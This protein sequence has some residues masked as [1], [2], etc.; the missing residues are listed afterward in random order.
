MSRI[1]TNVNSLIAQR[2]LGQQNKGL[3]QSLERLSTG[4]AINRGADNPAGLIASEKLR[5]DQAGL[6]AAIGNAQ[7]ADQIVNI[8][9]GGLQKVQDLLTQVN[10]LVGQTAS[11]AGLSDDEKAAN[12]LQ[13]DSILQTIDRIAAT[14]SF[15]GTKLLNG[16]YDFRVTGQSSAVADFKVNGAKITDGGTVAVQAIITNSAEHGTLFLSVGG[17]G[18]DLTSAG[19]SFV[20][21]LGGAKGTREFSFASGTTLATVATTLNT[22]KSTTGVSATASG[23]FLKVKSTEFG[24]DQF[25]SFR[26]IDDG[27]QAGKAHYASTTSENTVSTTNA[28]AFAS[29][30]NSVRGSGQ[31]VGALINGYSARG[32]GLTASVSTDALDL[33]ITLTSGGSG[34]QGLGSVSA[35][36]IQDSGARFNLGPTVDINN[37]VRL[38]IGEVASRKL[39]T[40]VDGY[41]SS[42]ASG[43][44]NNVID[45]DLG[46]AQ[47]VVSAAIDQISSLRGRLGAFQKYTVSSTVDALS[48][49]LENTTAAESAIRDTDFAKETA[50]LT[51]AQVLVQAAT[52][53]VAISRTAPQ[54][55]LQL[56]G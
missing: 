11:A 45:G 21:E 35:F 12:Q 6:S 32:K 19:A 30:T 9:E 7:R 29:I 20:F 28:T 56:L 17:T 41:L 39:G 44:S 38:G 22:F 14:T 50:S 51:R 16:T 48:V 25:V 24:S 10:G 31:D 5:A 52:S 27:G 26:V 47:K 36:T 55:I 13:I 23:N 46:Q 1:N 18:L 40:E 34:A 3:S 54:S 49:A 53:A 2:I 33:S 8:A 42:L 4:L 43:K 15:Q 37:Q